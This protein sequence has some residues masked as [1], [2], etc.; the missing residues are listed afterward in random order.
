MNIPNYHW[1]PTYAALTSVNRGEPCQEY[2]G[3]W[4]I[5]LP[6][7]HQGQTEHKCTSLGAAR[8]TAERI[9]MAFESAKLEYDPTQVTISWK[10]SDNDPRVGETWF[11]GFY[12]HGKYNIFGDY[13]RT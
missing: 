13:K 12:T 7:P 1:L 3:D 8:Q 9:L 10:C 2:P 6:I 4:I 11:T 5:H